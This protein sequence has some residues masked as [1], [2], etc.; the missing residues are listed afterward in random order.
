MCVEQEA[1]EL[2]GMIGRIGAVELVSVELGLIVTQI[3]HSW[4]PP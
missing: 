4:P 3:L 1:G 2:A